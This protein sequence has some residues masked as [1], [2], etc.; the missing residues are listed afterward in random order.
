[1]EGGR[2]GGGR[3][4]GGGRVRAIV[5]LVPEVG[6]SLSGSG[7]PKSTASWSGW[8]TVRTFPAQSVPSWTRVF[9]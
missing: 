3:M 5:Y 2:T 4:E 9:L 1:M 8:G 6:L 7:R